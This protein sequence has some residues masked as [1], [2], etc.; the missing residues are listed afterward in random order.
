M[1]VDGN[2]QKL[3]STVFLLGYFPTDMFETDILEYYSIGHDR[4][5]LLK[6]NPVLCN[7]CLQAVR[8]D[9]VSGC[10]KF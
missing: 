6:S 5:I 4:A 8:Q 1:S 10:A 9:F 3:C 2:A 7:R